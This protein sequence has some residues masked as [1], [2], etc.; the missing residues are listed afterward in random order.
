MGALGLRASAPGVPAAGRAVGWGLGAP[1]GPRGAAASTVGVTCVRRGF[2]TPRGH[3]SRWEGGHPATC[4]RH[5]RAG[6]SMPGQP[7]CRRSTATAPGSPACPVLP[8]EPACGRAPT[9]GGPA[10]TPASFPPKGLWGRG[11]QAA[12]GS[13]GGSGWSLG[14]GPHWPHGKGLS[15][16]PAPAAR[17]QQDPLATAVRHRPAVPCAR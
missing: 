11:T 9:H 12:A 17:P 15:W 1:E 3:G 10:H 6:A 16:V 13:R 7:G 2:W 4:H 5:G 14:A 8:Q